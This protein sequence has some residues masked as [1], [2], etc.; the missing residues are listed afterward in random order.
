MGIEVLFIVSRN[1]HMMSEISHPAEAYLDLLKEGG[2]G[3]DD[4]AQCV[5]N[6]EVGRF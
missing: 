1:F 6:S 3:K 2:K 5:I 4:L